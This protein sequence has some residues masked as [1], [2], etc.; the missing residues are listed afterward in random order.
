VPSLRRLRGLPSLALAGVVAAFGVALTILATRSYQQALQR[1][2]SVALARAAERY[3]LVI[4]SRLQACGSL[5]RAIQLVLGR[6]PDLDPAEFE[7][8]V[9]ALR[10]T[11]SF[12]SLQAV[13]YAPRSVD[14]ASGAV[15]YRYTL[16]APL[17]GN[18]RLVGL[19]VASQP[20]NLA[21]LQ[22]ARDT[23]EPQMSEPFTLVQFDRPGEQA[24]GVVIRLPVFADVLAGASV[25][26]RR[27]SERGSIVASFR[28]ATL[29]Q[30]V[31]GDEGRDLPYELRLRASDAA[32]A[33]LIYSSHRA[34]LSAAGDPMLRPALAR[35]DFG[36]QTW[37]LEL[38]PDARWYAATRRETAVV[39]AIGLLASLLL[40][41]WIA[42]LHS[43]Q[44]RAERLAERLAQRV[45]DT[46]QRFRQLTEL[47]PTAVLLVNREQGR[48]DYVNHAGRA[49]LGID[50]GEPPGQVQ[51][52]GLDPACLGESATTEAGDVAGEERVAELCNRQGRS[53][54]AVLRHA[55]MPG[56]DDQ[57]HWLLLL[58]D[59]T[60]RL[61]LT[62][63]LRYQAAHDALTGLLNR[64][65]F[66][67]RLQRA[68]ARRDGGEGQG[69]LLY[70]D[71]DQF[72]LI[73]DT[74]GHAAGDQLLARAAQ[75]LREAVPA[76]SVV[77]RLG[78]DEF[79]LILPGSTPEAIRAEGERL[80]QAIERMAF[81]WEGRRFALTASIGAVA[82][83]A[84][85][86]RPA[87]ELLAIADTAC[88]LAK[89]GGRNRVVVYDE[90]ETAS[91][92]RRNE[93]D[94][95]Q[96]IREALAEDRFCLY[97]QELQPLGDRPPEGVHFELLVRLR[98]RE[99]RLV[100]PGAFI[101]AAE[102][103][104][105]MPAVDRWVV[106]TALREFAHL[107]PAGRHIG[108]CAI[109]LSG[110]T[111]GDDSF[112]AFLL[113]QLRRADVPPERLCFEITETAA[114]AN[115]RQA[116]ALITELRQLGCKVALDDFGAGMSSFG[117]LK[118]LPVDYIKIDGSFIRE[119]DRD[120]M[121]QSIVR[122]ITEIGHQF[123]TQ[124]V[125]EFVNQPQTLLLLGGIGV[126]YAQGFGVHVPEVTPCHRMFVPVA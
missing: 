55:E 116:A 43:T 42:A 106:A 8:R 81:F 9:V 120:A 33:P 113:D 97:Y 28:I 101:P 80:R 34:G 61:Q 87:A 125:A 103:F 26:A 126:D 32:A 66:D 53:F 47:Q 13:G 95:V 78:G 3:D 89:E 90:D 62:A 91:R 105:V 38:L 6:Q 19:D 54:Q 2:A 18:E 1:E 111:M 44:R 77:A 96:R 40:A 23:D 115:F 25:A 48:I 99:G 10:A 4:E 27:A 107:H 31:M 76:G 57:G 70:L 104:G 63:Q 71:L 117:Y 98:D 72:K 82:F 73:N 49:L 94:W 67:H 102:R 5:V 46:E 35:I 121:S 100:P 86:Q 50:H 29:M 17:A 15:A 60:E 12:P 59:A 85:A 88:Y 14:P 118:N 92:Q 58:E 109:N 108:L 69:A 83:G 112:P 110:A 75:A 68:L 22:R 52:Y 24:D 20:A 64:R 74:C 51:D 124:V 119:I 84:R 30:G 56:D 21:V 36:G 41:G 11:R 123:R 79:G 93:M 114:V 45:K 37:R 65:E 122:A 39:G 7:Q 16:V